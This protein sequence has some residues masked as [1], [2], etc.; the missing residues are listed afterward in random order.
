MQQFDSATYATARLAWAIGADLSE[1]NL[2]LR[3]S[4]SATDPPS[5]VVLCLLRR[6]K[7][8]DHGHAL[9]V[10]VPAFNCYCFAF[11]PWR[12]AAESL[13]KMQANDPMMNGMVIK[14]SMA[15]LRRTSCSGRECRL[16]RDVEPEL[17]FE[18][19][20]WIVPDNWNANFQ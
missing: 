12:V 8:R 15:M 9:K 3:R 13:A 7:E 20:D 17:T 16:P 1:A 19:V 4:I 10:D 2:G 11:G 18:I 5:V 14:T 6:L